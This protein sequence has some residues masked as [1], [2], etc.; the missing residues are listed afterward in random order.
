MNLQSDKIIVFTSLPIYALYHAHA[1]L[2]VNHVL[3]RWRY[4]PHEQR[5]VSATEYK[6]GFKFHALLLCVRFSHVHLYIL[7]ISLCS[8]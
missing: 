8:S 6:S 7:S 1:K 4:Q 3:R 5:L 2:Y